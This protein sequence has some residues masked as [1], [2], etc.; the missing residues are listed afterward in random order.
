MFYEK[1]SLFAKDEDP[2]GHYLS[3]DLIIEYFLP[4]VN[5]G[6]EDLFRL[7]SHEWLH[8]LFDWATEGALHEED[9]INSDGEHFIMR[10]LNFV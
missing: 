8:A 6:E 3:D 1:F 7:I 9:K 5:D 2:A 4:N 10:V